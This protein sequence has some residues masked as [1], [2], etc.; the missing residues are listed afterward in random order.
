[1]NEKRRHRRIFAVAVGAFLLIGGYLVLR[2][3]GWDFDLTNFR[4]VQTGGIALRFEPAGSTVSLDGHIVDNASGLFPSGDVFLQNLLPRRYHVTVT[5]DGYRGWVKDLDVHPGAVSAAQEIKLWP[6]MFTVDT[7]ATSTDAFWV[8]NQGVVLKD[9][10][11]HL[12]LGSQALRGDR[13][14]LS[15]TDA[16]AIVVAEGTTEFLIDLTNPT[17]A[18]NLQGLFNSLRSRTFG[19][20]ATAGPE[21][22]AFHPFSLQKVL[23]QATSSLYALDYRRVALQELATLATTTGRGGTVVTPR[24]VAMAESNTKAFLVTDRNELLTLNLV[25]GTA[26]T[27]SFPLASTT[28]V[29]E[30]WA[31]PDSNYLVFQDSHGML[32]IYDTS[33][34]TLTPLASGIQ[35]VAFSPE[36][37]RLAYLT[38]DDYIGVYVLA[39]YEGDT[40][41]PQG[42]LYRFSVS[43]LGAME[44][45]EWPSAFP[46]YLLLAGNNRVTVTEVDPRAPENAYVL[47]PDVTSH[48]LAGSDLYLLNSSGALTRVDLTE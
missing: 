34:L 12:Q 6:A 43:G 22:L 19:L 9:A 38:N 30:L 47:F 1:M 17:V 7:L 45:L 15:R 3:I 48:A 23:L 21:N 28:S 42:T 29:T 46:N 35:A 26:A 14:V 13:V 25:L 37:K 40:R 8:T 20:R 27:S 10:D 2:T 32:Q 18:V 4:V 41:L 44:S 16:D 39:D 36:G 31:S 11:G 33:S 5:H 24:F